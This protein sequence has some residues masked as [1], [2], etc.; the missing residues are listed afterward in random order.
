MANMLKMMK[1]VRQVKKMQKELARKTVEVS[2]PDKKVTVFARGDMSIKA[3][4]IE[5]DVLQTWDAERLGKVVASTVNGALDAAKK[6]AASDMA[7]LTQ[8]IDG[9]SGMFGG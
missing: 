3:V 9:L 4:R 1:Q 8:G 2:S 5:P 6:A 7:Q